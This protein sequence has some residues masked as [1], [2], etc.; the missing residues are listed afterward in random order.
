MADASAALRQAITLDPRFAAPH[1]NLGRAQR[2]QAL[3]AK[4]NGAE[5]RR[6]W[7]GAA[8]SY[9]RA[10]ELDAKSAAAYGGLGEALMWLG[11]SAEAAAAKEQ[12]ARLL[13]E[14]SGRTT[15]NR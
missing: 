15:D 8:A 6:F 10:I 14:Q 4:G 3:S 13:A 1:L 2:D 11:E 5:A 7:A 12:A 9:R